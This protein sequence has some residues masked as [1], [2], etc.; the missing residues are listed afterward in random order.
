M[1][2]PL[3]AIDTSRI[4][5]GR[6]E[7]LRGAV[8]ELAAFVESNEPRPIAYEVYLDEDAGMMTVIQVHPDSASMELHL[9]V[10]GPAFPR[11]TELLELQT[12]DLFGSPSEEL[13]RLVRK[14][15]ELLGDVPV[16]VHPRHAGFVR[17]LP[18]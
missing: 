12:I 17:A 2:E 11:F 16:R 10:A 18:D 4:R 9:D 7:E 3:V 5:E 15:A 1:S 8:D 13:V 6:F 14:K